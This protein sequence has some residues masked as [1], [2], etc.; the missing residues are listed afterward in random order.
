LIGLVF[1]FSEIEKKQKG[2]AGPGMTHFYATLLQQSEKKH[3]AVMAAA[4][5]PTIGPSMPGDPA[6]LAIKPPTERQL[7]DIERAKKARAEGKEVELNDDNQIVDKR[8][9]LSAGLNLA[10]KNTRDLAAY[11]RDKQNKAME[12]VVNVHTAVGSAAS[13]REIEA[14]R[15]QE[16]EAQLAEE[17]KRRVIEKEREEEEIRQKAVKRKNDD[18]AV[19]S[20]RERYLERKRRKLDNPAPEMEE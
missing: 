18:D 12:E 17:E 13:R 20:A 2:K 11:R 3:A 16:I 1:I 10:A 5:Q 15:R 4:S 14:R 8:D 9:L 7:T 19:M 6:N